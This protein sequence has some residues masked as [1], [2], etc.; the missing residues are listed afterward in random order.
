MRLATEY[1][2]DLGFE[3]T[4]VSA[5]HLFDLFCASNVEE[6]H[7]E[8]KGL[9]GGPS[10]I[11]LTSNEVMNARDFETTTDLFIVH[12]IVLLS[13]QETHPNSSQIIRYPDWVPD[14][15][16]LTATHLTYRLLNR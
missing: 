5:T 15:I 10:T 3:V 8:V 7:A 12:D 14:D 11:Q 4:D 9:Q 13:N 2:E 16:D 6:I 1:Y